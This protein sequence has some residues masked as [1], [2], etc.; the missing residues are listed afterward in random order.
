M[1][2]SF[3][4]I[5]IAT[6]LSSSISFAE[7]KK[8]S[9]TFGLG[10]DVTYIGPKLELAYSFNDMIS[11][12]GGLHYVSSAKL[13]NIPAAKNYEPKVL[14]NKSYKNLFIPVILDIYPL[15]SFNKSRLRFSMGAGYMDRQLYEGKLTNATKFVGIV[16]VGYESTFSE[17]GSW[18][19]DLDAGLQFLDSSLMTKNIKPKSSDW[20]IVPTFK[21]GLIYKL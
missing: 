6:I 14:R 16:S 21:I 19:Y 12:R 15:N 3:V 2:K 7:D 20:K 9:I 10:M 13:D 18:G 1:K 8:K 11:I 5:L 4:I 17:D